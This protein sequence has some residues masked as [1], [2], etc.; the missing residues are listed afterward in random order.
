[1]FPM[2]QSLAPN[3]LVDKCGHHH[4]TCTDLK[5]QRFEVLESLRSGDDTILTSHVD[6]FI[7]I[8]KETWNRHHGS[9]NV[10]SSHFPI[11]YVLTT[12][13]GNGYDCGYHMLEYLAKWQGIKVP[14]IRKA[15]VAELH[16]IL[17]WNW[18][19][20]GDFNKRPSP[21]D[22]IEEAVKP[23]RKKYK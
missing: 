3:N 5:H 11:E 12:K 7:N 13:Q 8:L 16:K 6:F 18:V 10:Q 17:T 4:T 19:T 23:A 21:W 9:S 1:M 15:C 14:S 22:F 2:F 20:N